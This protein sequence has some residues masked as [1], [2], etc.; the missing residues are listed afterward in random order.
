MTVDL[1]CAELADLTR[2]GAGLCEPR[3]EDWLPYWSDEKPLIPG[4]RWVTGREG[5]LTT[6]G[7]RRRRVATSERDRGK[8]EK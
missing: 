6:N 8:E 2:R 1:A 7:F 5:A 4:G 3:A